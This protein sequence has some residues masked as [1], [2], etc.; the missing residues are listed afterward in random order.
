M[1]D[2]MGRFHEAVGD[3]AGILEAYANGNPEVR[4][5]D[6]VDAADVLFDAAY[7][8]NLGV[9]PSDYREAE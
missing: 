3:F 7:D 9:W 1:Q 5:L 2:A 8:A 4:H 6:V